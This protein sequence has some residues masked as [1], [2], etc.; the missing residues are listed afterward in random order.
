MP[1]L[2]GDVPD[3]I[4]QRVLACAACHAQKDRDDAYFPRISGKPEGYLYNQLVNFR[5]G[6]RQAREL[7]GARGPGGRRRDND[8]G[9]EQPV[10]GS[11]HGVPRVGRAAGSATGSSLSRARPAG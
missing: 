4:G 5:D 7:L 8:G 1:G 11:V 9:G 2:A 6:R 10:G 3:T